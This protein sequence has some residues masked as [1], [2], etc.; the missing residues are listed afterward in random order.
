MPQQGSRPV[1]IRPIPIAN[2][3]QS[4]LI[5]TPLPCPLS[6]IP[7]SFLSLGDR[8]GLET[9]AT[10]YPRCGCLFLS[11]VSFSD[12]L[13]LPKS[14]SPGGTGP[15]CSSK[16]KVQVEEVPT[17]YSAIQE[18]R[19]AA[20]A[21]PSASTYPGPP[22]PAPNPNLN[23]LLSPSN[24]FLILPGLPTHH[25]PP[26]FARGSSKEAAH[27]WIPPVFFFSPPAAALPCR[28]LLDTPWLSIEQGNRWRRYFGTQSHTHPPLQQAA[29]SQS[30]CWTQPPP[31]PSLALSA[32]CVTAANLVHIPDHPHCLWLFNSFSC[33]SPSSPLPRTQFIGCDS[34]WA[35]EPPT[36]NVEPHRASNSGNLSRDEIGL[37]VYESWKQGHGRAHLSSLTVLHAYCGI[38][39]DESTFQS[40]L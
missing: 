39:F 2:A 21:S 28:S 3:T 27:L 24:P 6:H 11:F 32:C 35:R 30:L 9:N 16:S 10:W 14:T 29:A 26:D 31:A 17:D 7:H 33:R 25:P 22:T 18:I 4:H 15:V 23:P 19:E 12:R 36:E 37:R 1:E 40:L 5:I 34:L 8:P 13:P 38:T 20:I